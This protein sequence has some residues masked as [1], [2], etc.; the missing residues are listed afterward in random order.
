MNELDRLSY[1]WR[2]PNNLKSID[3]VREAECILD[4]VQAEHKARYALNELARTRAKLCHVQSGIADRKLMNAA[5]DVGVAR[6]HIVRIHRLGWEKGLGHF[7]LPYY[8][9]EESKYVGTIY[10]LI[11]IFPFSF[12]NAFNYLATE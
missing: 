10:S 8:Q 6:S 12:T 9:E 1:L 3:E 4:V 5:M 7:T 2:D 11:L